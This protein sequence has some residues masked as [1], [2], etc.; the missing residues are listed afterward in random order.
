[1]TWLV[2]LLLGWLAYRYA[3]RRRTGQPVVDA[4]GLRRRVAAAREGASI[5]VR[6]VVVLVLVVFSATLLAAGTTGLVLSPRW[7]GGLLTGLAV[8][9]ALATV[10]EIVGLRRIVQ[11]RRRRRRENDLRREAEARPAGRTP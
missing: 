10:P 5:A 2:R 6:L 8:V 1:V 11:A 7:L 4:Q 9:F 3:R